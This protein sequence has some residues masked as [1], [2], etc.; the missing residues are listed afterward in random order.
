MLKPLDIVEFRVGVDS[1]QAGTTATV[2][3]VAGDSALVEVSD[4]Q[5]RTLDT[6]SVPL[7]AV[8]RLD[9]PDQRRL[10]V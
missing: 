5:G 8:R 3:E 6:I 9:A 2:L 10:A 4:E 7:S 1:W